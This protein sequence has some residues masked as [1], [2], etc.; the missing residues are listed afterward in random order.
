MKA[1]IRM[2]KLTVYCIAVLATYF[3]F[4][5]QERIDLSNTREFFKNYGLT[6][7]PKEVMV[8][9]PPTEEPHFLLFENPHIN[10][11]TIERKSVEF[12]MVTGDHLPFNS[13]PIP[14]RTFVFPLDFSTQSDTLNISIDKS[15]EN[16]FVGLKLLSESEWEDYS[17]T[18]FYIRGFIVGIYF[19][20]LL[21]CLALLSKTMGR[22]IGFFT[23]Y[24]IFSFI[25]IFNDVGIWFQYLWPS[26]P[27]FH[28][29][30]RPL[31]STLSILAFV[32]YL[33]EHEVLKNNQSVR[34]LGYW[35][36]ILGLL[37][38]VLF[39]AIVLLIISES[40]KYFVILLNSLFLGSLFLALTLISL[41]HIKA[42]SDS[43][44]VLIAIA[45][46]S[47][48]IVNQTL[49][50]FG[51]SFNTNATFHQFGPAAFL[52]I[53]LMAMA[54]SLFQR[55][56]KNIQIAIE[57]NLHLRMK[58]EFILQEKIKETEQNERARFA[59]NIHDHIGSILAGIKLR[60]ALL[61]ST[62]SELTK[63]HLEP[64]SDLVEEGLTTQSILISEA[65]DSAINMQSFKSSLNHKIN[66]ALNGIEIKKV[67]KFDDR[68]N[69]I[70]P[71]QKYHLLFIV[72]E[73]IS[74]TLK[75]A[76]ASLI[77]ISLTR[78]EDQIL[79][80][81][82]DD[83]AGM[84]ANSK[85]QGFGLKSIKARVEQ[86]NGIVDYKTL[87]KGV[88]VEVRLKNTDHEE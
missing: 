24:A 11:L 21:I 18:D 67:F 81:Y 70:A 3:L 40:L 45:V 52:L 75:H 50:Q 64:L 23:A 14:F 41:R 8:L 57:E 47:L 63:K 84:T 54:Y 4:A 15:G 38:L 10:K 43:A 61:A 78:V 7:S 65:P 2:S 16:L 85:V 26:H 20:L 39:V 53:Q 9:I 79:F 28:A 55:N 77:E 35:I 76:N 6:T 12:S 83:G 88:W 29:I 69:H 59:R 71:S 31:F 72:S 46:Y 33:K 87:E 49:I 42:V 27:A 37:K 13:R 82:R 34:Q 22:Q 36:T 66:A 44:F 68:V 56:N 80:E 60:I 48:F 19:I 30:S 25:W 32:F 5:Q 62:S 51:V 17:R 73:L 1:L 86:M 74:N 58:Q